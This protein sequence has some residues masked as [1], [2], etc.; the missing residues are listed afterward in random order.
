MQ[1]LPL[2]TLGPLVLGKR[3]SQWWGGG[4]G[5]GLADLRTLLLVSNYPVPLACSPTPTASRLAILLLRKLQF[6]SSFLSSSGGLLGLWVSLSI[7]PIIFMSYVHPCPTWPLLNGLNPSGFGEGR[8]VHT[9]SNGHLETHAHLQALET[10]QQASEDPGSGPV[11][12]LCPL[13]DV[14]GQV[15]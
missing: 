15:P 4:V 11:G 10:R 12:L 8:E 13:G 5:A 1:T 3:S 14:T 2:A 9:C 6:S 7:C